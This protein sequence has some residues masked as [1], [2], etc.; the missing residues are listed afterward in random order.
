MPNKHKWVLVVDDEDAVIIAFEQAFAGQSE[1]VLD[2]ARTVRGALEK[3]AHAQYDIVVLD[4]KLD[5]NS[6]AGM[7]ILKEINRLEIRGRSR[8]QS[9]IE[10]L[11]ILMSG[12]TPFSDFM[13]HA[14]ELGCLSFIDKRVQFD[15][16]FIRRC[17]NRLRVPLLPP[18]TP[19]L[20]PPTAGETLPP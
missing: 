2:T 3:L 5:G 11:I 12:S 16:A 4:L 20:T 19:P 17:L 8:G 13:A 9:V 15:A 1:Y 7:G 14:H 6:M 10:S 18:E